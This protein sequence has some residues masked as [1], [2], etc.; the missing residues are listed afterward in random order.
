MDQKP[1]FRLETRSGIP[2]FE[3]ESNLANDVVEVPRKRKLDPV[4]AHGSHVGSLATGRSAPRLWSLCLWRG[5]TLASAGGATFC[6]CATLPCT[7]V[8]RAGVFGAGLA[9]GSGISLTADCVA[10]ARVTE[11]AVLPGAAFT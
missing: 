11:V 4:A 9:V 3:V 2:W 1:Y 8:T 7:G 6:D 10:V 5:V